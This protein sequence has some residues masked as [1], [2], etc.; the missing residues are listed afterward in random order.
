MPDINI[1]TNTCKVV[2][3][4]NTDL[5]QMPSIVNKRVEE[6]LAYFQD[7]L[8]KTIQSEKELMEFEILSSLVIEKKDDLRKSMKEDRHKAWKQALK[9]AKGNEQKAIEI[10]DEL[11]P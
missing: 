10:F 1:Y 4:Q 8:S 5:K 6:R 2:D 9:K 7:K 11:Y 3:M